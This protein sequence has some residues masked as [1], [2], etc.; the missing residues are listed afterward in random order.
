VIIEDPALIV[1]DLATPTAAI[2]VTAR[3]GPRD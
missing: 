1:D 3:S 2:D